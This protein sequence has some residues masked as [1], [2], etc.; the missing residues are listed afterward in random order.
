M[1]ELVTQ[2]EA[3]NTWLCHHEDAAGAPAAPMVL[4]L[5]DT[6]D[7]PY[8]VENGRRWLNCPDCGTRWRVWTQLRVAKPSLL[9]PVSNP[10]RSYYRY[11]HAP[12]RDVYRVI[13]LVVHAAPLISVEQ[14]ENSW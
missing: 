9:F 10:E 4:R 14:F 2:I 3:D 13:D 11:R 8:F 6:H 1:S 5:T 12:F 7:W